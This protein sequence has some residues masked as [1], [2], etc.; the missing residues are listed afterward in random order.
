MAVCLELTQ[1]VDLKVQGAGTFP[2]NKCE[3]TSTPIEA[4]NANQEG[5]LSKTRFA[6]APEHRSQELILVDMS[7]KC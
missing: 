2:L 3:T 7:L 6:I 5:Y 4:E 1:L